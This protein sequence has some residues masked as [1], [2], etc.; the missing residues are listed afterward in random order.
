MCGIAGIYNFNFEPVSMELLLKMTDIQKHRGPDD[1]GHYAN[2]EIGLGHRR[3]SIIDL[4]FDG[5][6]PMCNEDERVWIVFNGEIYNYIELTSDLKSKGHIFKSKT[7]TE[8]IIHA[9]EE[10]GIECLQK[11]NGMFSFAIWDDR[12]R[13]LF[14]A[15]DRMGIK[16]F[17]YYLDDNKFSFASEIKAILVD[18]SIER[19]P[20]DQIIYEYLRHGK[21]DHTED[22]FFDGI[23]HLMPAHYIIIENS[24]IKIHRYWD[25]DTSNYSKDADDQES[26]EK[27]L[28]LFK[29]SVKIRLRSDVP[30]GTCLS[31][32][33]DSSSIV[34]IL[35]DLLTDKF[36]QKT[37]SSCFEDET[38]DERRFIK[39]VTEKTNTESNFVFPSG[40]TLFE[41][42]LNLVW[43]QEEPFVSTSIYAQWNVMR[44]SKENDVKVLL[45]GQG[46]DELLAGYH[47]YFG[48]FYLDLLKSIQ[49]LTLMKETMYFVNYYSYSE[50]FRIASMA[51]RYIIPES[52]MSLL[53]SSVNTPKWLDRDFVRLHS[54]KVS[55]KSYSKQKF[56]KQLD[57]ELY[58]RLTSTSLPA[59][60]RY[61]DKNSMAFSI[62]ARVPFLDYRLIEYISSL[63]SSQKIKNGAT[64][65][66]L[67]NAMK[68]ILPEEVRNRM[69]KMGFVTPENIWLRTTLK[70]EI[71]GILG[72][73]SF[74][75]RKYF[76]SRELQREY[77]EYCKAEK[78]TSS[79]I[80]RWV[81]LELWF[82]VFIDKEQPFFS[83]SQN[84]F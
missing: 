72:S 6:Q 16:P 63:P 28:E 45:D 35:N 34:C 44:L 60:L 55:H 15:R 11:F 13:K 36:K 69:D 66:V 61:E 32:G 38:Y 22:T 51:L 52:I 79:I 78:N 20:N 56:D 24:D 84:N 17:Y 74:K 57:E 48:G 3:L 62:E 73:E 76:N 83:S 14:C 68:G 9:Y 43:H 70:D 10:Y 7:D 58:Q 23:K 82:R 33:L 27:L 12:E 41:E 37:F 75:N 21:L 8:V 81:N 42:I 59:L 29:N 26:A 53:R 40:E 64:K 80:W 50:L 25:L 2:G 47:L 65:I 67:R 49:F 18:D 77:E 4:S 19:K 1:E 31:G 30:L 39:Y 46:A 54:K 71:T 5:H